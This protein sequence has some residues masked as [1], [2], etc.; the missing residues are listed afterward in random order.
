MFKGLLTSGSRISEKN[1][2]QKEKTTYKKAKISKNNGL[3]VSYDEKE[4][5]DFLP[6]LMEEICNR[7]QS[8]KIDSITQDI[9][10]QSKEFG[11]IEDQDQY[12]PE[13]LFNPKAIDFIRRCKTSDEAYEILDFLLK[14]KELST[15][16]YKNYKNCISQGGLKKLIDESG[17]PKKPGYYERKYRKNLTEQKD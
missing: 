14:R 1:N 2:N 4:I 8:V 3:N 15:E 12:N 7:K 10:T 17:G 16:D 5:S 11:L 13:E 9:E 6:H